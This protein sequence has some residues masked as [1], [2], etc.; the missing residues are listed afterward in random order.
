[1]T[2]GVAAS[3]GVALGGA[4]RASVPV[5]WLAIIEGHDAPVGHLAIDTARGCPSPLLAD[6]LE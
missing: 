4:E 3:A 1:M 6:A 2:D 5:A